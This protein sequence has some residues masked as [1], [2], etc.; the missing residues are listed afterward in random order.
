MN[1][2]IITNNPL[3]KSK[4]ENLYNI[5]FLDTDYKG[6]LVATRDRIHLGHTLLTHP[7]SGSVK[8]NETPYKSI[9]ISK[10]AGAFD[11]KSLM[12]MEDALI[13]CEKFGDNRYKMTPSLLE[14]FMTIDLSLISGALTL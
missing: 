3:V 1:E 10:S 11:S 9:L 5:T 12:I 13:T 8:P 14:D 6:V 7:L 4:Y 2:I